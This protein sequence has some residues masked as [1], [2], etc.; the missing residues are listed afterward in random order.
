MLFT[1]A[2]S[3]PG[4]RVLKRLLERADYSEIWCGVN[5]RDVP[6]THPKL[7]RFPLNLAAEIS[8]EPITKPLD[9]V[10][11]FAGLTHISNQTGYWEV[12]LQ[13]TKNLA[14]QARARGCQRFFYVSTRCA[15]QGSGGYGE[16]KLAAEEALKG[17]NWES[18][19][20]VRPAEIFGG[21]SR[22]GL[23]KLM[24]MAARLHIAPLLWGHRKIQFAPIHIDDFV[25]CVCRLLSAEARGIE[26]IELCGPEELS[27]PA[28]ALRLARKYRAV[29]IP[30]WWPALAL[31]L[32]ALRLLGLPQVT[33][34][35]ISRLV[36][37]KTASVSSPECASL[38][39][40][41]FPQNAISGINDRGS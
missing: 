25:H 14:K 13:G 11:H 27:G 34:D 18:L 16:S 26:T 9:L 35:Q 30:L 28:V 24:W 19:L 38:P 10:I 8:L 3:A 22:E 20:I 39:M 31:T 1:G 33:P 37:P 5:W 41:R 21:N 6:L 40:H 2:S 4:A 17:M 36:G 32:K 23:D 7:R 12:N 15:A 29:P